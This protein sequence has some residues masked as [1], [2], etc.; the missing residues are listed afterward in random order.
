MSEYKP[1][2]FSELTVGD[3]ISVSFSS[4]QE[5]ILVT[6]V[7]VDK[8]TEDT[9]RAGKYWFRKDFSRYYLVSKA[10]KPLPTELGAVVE[11]TDGWKFVRVGE[12][13]WIGISPSTG[14]SPAQWSDYEVDTSSRKVEA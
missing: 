4:P 14:R 10:K 9:V 12:D 7:E 5:E 6:C 13:D 2:K 1:I 3:I 8:I 11:H